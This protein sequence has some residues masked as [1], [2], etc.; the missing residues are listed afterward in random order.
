MAKK[1]PRIDFKGPSALDLGVV[2]N[3]PE[4]KPQ[5]VPVKISENREEGAIFTIKSVSINSDNTNIVTEFGEAKE[6]SEPQETKPVLSAGE[7]SVAVHII[8]ADLSVVPLIPVVANPR[9]ESLYRKMIRDYL[10]RALGTQES[11]VIKLSQMKE[12]L[13]IT[14]KTLYFHLKVLRQTEFEIKKLRYGTEVKRR[15]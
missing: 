9:R 4:I 11:V 13:E 15:K 2:V 1:K 6:I 14:E 7:K 10:S 5:E 8:N 12:D 3:T